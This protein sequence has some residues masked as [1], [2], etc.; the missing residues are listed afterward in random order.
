M[1]Q[2]QWL[3]HLF[4]KDMAAW[5]AK[6]GLTNMVSTGPASPEEMEAARGYLGNPQTHEEWLQACQDKATSDAFHEG[7]DD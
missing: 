2:R 5:H 1:N 3:D 7:C 4:K 6:H